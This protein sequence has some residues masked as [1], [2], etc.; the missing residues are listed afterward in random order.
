M[1]FELAQ[2]IKMQV[3]ATYHVQK[4][5][6]VHLTIDQYSLFIAAAFI[7]WRRYSVDFWRAHLLTGFWIEFD[8]N[9]EDLDFL[10]PHVLVHEIQMNRYEF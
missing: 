7:C 10:Q 8:E 6:H 3:L 2:I 1:L 4:V 9:R 5:C